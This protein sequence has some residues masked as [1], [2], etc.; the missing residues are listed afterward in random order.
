M[1]IRTPSWDSGQ[2]MRATVKRWNQIGFLSLFFLTL[3]L[4]NQNALAT[5]ETH[6]HDS[7]G[8]LSAW[9]PQT[10]LSLEDLPDDML[11]EILRRMDLKTL[12]S[13]RAVNQRFLHLILDAQF[14]KELRLT[15]EDSLE[16]TPQVSAQSY[17]SGSFFK[18]TYPSSAIR[19]QFQTAQEMMDFFQDSQSQE[20][21]KIELDLSE[22]YSLDFLTLDS[23]KQLHSWSQIQDLSVIARFYDPLEEEYPFRL[24]HPRW[25]LTLLRS[26]K[27]DQSQLKEITILQK[28]TLEHSH[29]TSSYYKREQLSLDELIALS[30]LRSLRHFSS[31]TRIRRPRHEGDTYLEELGTGAMI[32][33]QPEVNQNTTSG[34]ETWIQ[35]LMKIRDLTE[36]DPIQVIQMGKLRHG[37]YRQAGDAPITISPL[38][39]QVEARGTQKMTYLFQY[40]TS[41]VLIEQ[42]RWEENFYLELKNLEPFHFMIF[43][44]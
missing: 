39:E 24:P 21:R 28:I 33:L 40:R 14:A 44:S 18:A 9:Q 35:N 38:L 23:L 16:Q 17:F 27:S 42:G 13:A 20:Y 36:Q 12:I 26:L 11:R 5:E 37:T 6:P 10:E 4:F 7:P 19:I 41:E 1:K 22:L 29:Q 34:S 31:V 43:D 32:T 2:K 30:E 25:L 3:R 15:R 8:M